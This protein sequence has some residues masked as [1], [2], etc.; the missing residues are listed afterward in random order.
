M[1]NYKGSIADEIW[2]IYYSENAWKHCV[3]YSLSIIY[4]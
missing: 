2:S 3:E 4:S 1:L